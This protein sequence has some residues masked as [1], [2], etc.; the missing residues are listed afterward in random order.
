MSLMV[1]ALPFPSMTVPLRIKISH[2]MAVSVRPRR[3]RRAGVDGAQEPPAI[4]AREQRIVG[5]R[6]LSR[7]GE[8]GCS[9]VG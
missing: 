7:S 1:P 9:R 8:R 6:A 4:L 5:A 3:Q 2:V